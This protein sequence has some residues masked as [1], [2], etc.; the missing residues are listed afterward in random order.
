MQ[1]FLPLYHLR[2][3]EHSALILNKTISQNGQNT[4]TLT[5]KQIVVSDII[6]EVRNHHHHLCTT[7]HGRVRQKRQLELGMAVGVFV[8]SVASSIIGVFS[9]GFIL[10]EDRQC[11][12]FQN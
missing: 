6:H 4:P 11:K 10:P 5:A 12:A 7:D 9:S 3:F 2:L 8:M 1:A